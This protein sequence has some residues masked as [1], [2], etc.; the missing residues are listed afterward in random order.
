MVLVTIRLIKVA[1]GV[2]RQKREVKCGSRRERGR[3]RLRDSEMEMSLKLCS[4][5]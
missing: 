3:S 5:Y 4:S 2:K 1:R